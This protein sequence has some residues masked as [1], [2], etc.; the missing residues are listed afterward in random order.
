MSASPETRDRFDARDN[1]DRSGQN[2]S[3]EAEREGAS[4]GFAHLE[5]LIERAKQG[6]EK[7]WNALWHEVR[8][9]L[10]PTVRCL[11]P[12]DEVRDVIQEVAIAMWRGLASFRG[13]ASLG[14][15]VRK[16]AVRQ[17]LRTISKEKRRRHLLHVFA[18]ETCRERES[19]ST[20]LPPERSDWGRILR[21]CFLALHPTDRTALYLKYLRDLTYPQVADALGCS[22]EAAKLRCH[23]ARQNLRKAVLERVSGRDD[24]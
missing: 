18:R 13:Q 6:D 11:V 5:S 23:R 9:T 4:S 21:Q 1:H 15:W 3:G 16:I 10:L 12:D 14:A 22:E 7:T 17:C 2:L 24:L 20:V 8:P 19:R